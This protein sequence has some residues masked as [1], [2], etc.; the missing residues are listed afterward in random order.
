MADIRV[1]IADDE[2]V[3]R[4]ALSDLIEATVGMTVVAVAADADEA[5]AAAETSRPDV[6]LVDVRMP[7]GGPKATRGIMHC[8]PETRVLALS[9]SGGGETVLEMIQAGAAGYLVKGILPTEVI[10][11][12]RHVAMGETP[13]SP[14]VAGGVVDRIRGQLNAE[15]KEQQ[16]RKLLLAQLTIALDEDGLDMVYQPILDLQTRNLVGVESLARFSMEPRRP[17]NEWFAAAADLGLATRLEVTA[18]SRAIA[19]REQLPPGVFMTVNL[20]PETLMMAR[21]GNT[22]PAD[23]AARVVIELTEHTRVADY[24]GLCKSFHPLRVTGVALAVDDAGA[25]FASLRHILELAPQFIKLDISITQKIEHDRAAFA[26]AVALTSFAGAI[27]AEIIAEGIETEGQ[28]AA[29]TSMGIR[30]GQGY[31]LGKPGP[32]S[33]LAHLVPGGAR[34]VGG[35]AR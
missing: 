33:D 16:R 1:L 17:P 28:V 18:L 27:D 26:L 24:E 12:I 10:A 19:R 2:K 25:G 14:Q 3:M 22:I 7:G 34:A 9:A 31:H 21:L 5:I 8:C 13:I 11:G 20:S 29:V 4:D 35:V 6:A 23:F 32:L 30:L 15:D